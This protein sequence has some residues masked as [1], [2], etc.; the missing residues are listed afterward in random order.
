M[1][2]SVRNGTISGTLLTIAATIN[3]DDILKTAI[4][5]AIGAVVSFMVSLLLKQCIRMIQKK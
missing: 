4:L 2:T 5:A 1:N 3:K